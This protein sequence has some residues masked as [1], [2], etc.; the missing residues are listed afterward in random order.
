[1]HSNFVT[2]SLDRIIDFL[3]DRQTKEMEE[4][5]RDLGDKHAMK[6]IRMEYMD[7]FIPCFMF[8]L[9]P[10]IKPSWREVIEAA[11]TA[12]LSR[13]INMLKESITF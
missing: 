4:F 1:M 3:R 9:E 7:L 5:I 2:I 10:I 8:A 12:L 6:T 11:W 13:I